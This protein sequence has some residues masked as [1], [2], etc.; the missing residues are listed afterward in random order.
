[1]SNGFSVVNHVGITVKNL[2]KAIPF[3]EAL[4]GVK[5]ANVDQIGGKRMAAVQGLDDT[6]IKYANVHLDNI[7]IDILEYVEPKS[8]TASYSNEQVSAMHM[9][10]EVDDIQAA[11]ERLKKLGVEPEGEPMYFT[12]DDGLKNGLGTGVVYF[13]DPDG[14]HLELI[15]PK[16]PFQRG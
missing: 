16:G 8:S 15:E 10:F 11:V 4:F 7:N 14:A 12:E 1:M 6:L 5:V 9:C 3:Y 13:Q 2:D